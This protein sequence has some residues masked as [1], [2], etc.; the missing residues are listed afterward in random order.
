MCFVFWQKME[1]LSKAWGLS[2]EQMKKENARLKAE[3]LQHK[4]SLAQIFGQ[5]SPSS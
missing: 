4:S 2:L 1:R 5:P 3:N